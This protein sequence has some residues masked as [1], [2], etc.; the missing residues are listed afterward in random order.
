MN[1]QLNFQQSFKDSFILIRSKLLGVH[2]LLQLPP[3]KNHWCC[4]SDKQ[5]TLQSGKIGVVLVEPI[6]GEGGIYSATKAFLQALRTTCH[7]AGSLFVFDEMNK[8]NSTLM[9]YRYYWE[10]IF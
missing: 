10:K 3:L 4:C 9:Q 5:R 8:H 2:C 1:Q 6:Q 7:S